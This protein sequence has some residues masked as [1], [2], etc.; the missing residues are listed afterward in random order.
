[1]PRIVV[2]FRGADAKRRLS[3]LAAFERRALAHAM[4]TD[5]LATATTVGDTLLVAPAGAAQ[6]RSIAVDAGV[7]VIDDPGRGQGEAV[8]TALRT[9]DDGPVLIVNADVPSVRPADLLALLGQLP[10]GGIALVEAADGTTN[11]LALS[12]PRLF[13]R[14]YGEGSAA[15]FRRHAEGLEL[16]FAEVVLPGLAQ[17]VDTPA[18]LEALADRLGPATAAVRAGLLAIAAA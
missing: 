11:A 12:S 2:P 15:R 1:V 17:D 3:P 9:L 14:L 16:P 8:A 7:E 13:E 5:V 18:D 10:A 6:A 4:L